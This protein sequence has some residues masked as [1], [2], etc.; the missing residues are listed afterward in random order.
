MNPMART[1]AALDP[2]GGEVAC[3]DRDPRQHDR[4]PF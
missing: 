3:C 1:A 4:E 2:G